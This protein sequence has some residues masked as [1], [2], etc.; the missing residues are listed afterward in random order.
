MHKIHCLS[1]LLLI[2]AACQI[3]AMDNATHLILAAD[4]NPDLNSQFVIP[5]SV[6]NN[7]YLSQSAETPSFEYF[8]SKASDCIQ[9]EAIASAT[10]NLHQLAQL[11]K[12]D[13]KKGYPH[14]PSLK[15]L[16]NQLL[17]KTR[18]DNAKKV[19]HFDFEYLKSLKQAIADINS[20]LLH[21]A[22]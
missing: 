16:Y 10:E 7:L 14:L 19:I 8:I 2:T 20:K 22:K 9:H 6:E 11:I 13:P 4:S 17:P 3:L 15:Q 1:T 18:E 5:S 21:E 12:C